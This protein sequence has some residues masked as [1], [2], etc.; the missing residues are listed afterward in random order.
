MK[1][2]MGVVKSNFDYESKFESEVCSKSCNSRTRFGKS[3]VD[4]SERQ[5]RSCY[6]NS[7][8][9]ANLVGKSC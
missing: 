3:F 8:R 6:G 4:C 7:G 9:F 1:P 5:S 2:W